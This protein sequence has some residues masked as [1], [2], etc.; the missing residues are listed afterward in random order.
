MLGKVEL[1][2]SLSIF[3][4]SLSLSPDLTLLFFQAS[5]KA[6][7]IHRS[8]TGR[9]STCS[10]FSLQ[11][12]L[13]L[14]KN[15][16]CR[17][18]RHQLSHLSHV[19]KVIPVPQM[20]ENGCK[21]WQLHWKNVYLWV[22]AH[23]CR[24]YKES[25]FDHSINPFCSRL[26]ALFSYCTTPDH[27]VVASKHKL[28]TGISAYANRNSIFTRLVALFPLLCATSSDALWSSVDFEMLW[29]FSYKM[30]TR[31]MQE[32]EQKPNC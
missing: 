6:L 2:Q 20:S 24:Y 12:T 10:Y 17:T 11:S 8:R 29:I 9:G 27:L 22:K 19:L 26:P 23:R 5:F 7:W 13:K 32:N 1:P 21:W 3:A 31:E 15:K 28:Y 30:D 18:R 16:N 25:D 14:S 4:L